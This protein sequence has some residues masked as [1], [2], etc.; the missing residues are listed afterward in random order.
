MCIENIWEKEIKKK[1]KGALAG[2]GLASGPL[3]E[4]G[5]VHERAFPPP[6]TRTRV[7]ARRPAAPC[8]H[9]E[10]ARLCRRVARM[11]RGGHVVVGHQEPPVA[12]ASPSS[13]I[14]AHPLPLCRSRLP[15]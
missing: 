8:R 6:R 5:L 1:E 15:R 12:L 10:P 3:A 14:H 4:A 9:G 11:R 2:R 7:H 13:A